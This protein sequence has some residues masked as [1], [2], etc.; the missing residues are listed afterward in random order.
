[1]SKGNRPGV[2][3]GVFVMRDGKFLM[4][5]RHGA[6]GANTWSAP[7][8]HLEYGETWAECAE[9]ETLEETG[10]RL[11][12]VRFLGLTNDV[13]EEKKHYITI[14]M[15]ADWESGEPE[16]REPE[17]CL[18]WEWVSLE[19]LPERTFLPFENL[20]KGEFWGKFEKELGR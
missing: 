9:R 20:R 3:V 5:E 6:H 17:K 10:M 13:F 12:N 1:M 14:A 16:V 11:K 7:G 8:G 18:G 15:V 4:G 2:G 19:N